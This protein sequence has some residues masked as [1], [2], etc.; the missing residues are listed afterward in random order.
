MN[1]TATLLGQM[2]TFAL[3]VWFVSKYLWGPMTAMMEERQKKIADGLAASDRGQK[4]LELAQ[5][6]AKDILHEAKLQAAD[7]VGNAQKRSSEIIEEAKVEAGAENDRLKSAALAE[8]DQER[9]RA[10][11][12]LREQVADLVV[13]GVEKVMMKEVN[14][15]EHGAFLEKLSAKL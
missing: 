3:L 13:E 8:I 7:I 10:R 2:I 1:V 14:A 11:E 15:K 9:N 6:K 5:E 4:D 12:Q